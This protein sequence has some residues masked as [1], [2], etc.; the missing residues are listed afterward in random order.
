MISIVMQIT[1]DGNPVEDLS[2][3]WLRKQVGVVS[4]E[5]VLFGVSIAENIRYGRE[6]AT[7]DDIEIAATMAN[8]HGFIDRLPQVKIRISVK[9][10][11]IDITLYISMVK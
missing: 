8:A 4:Q 3:Y 6:D 11:G 1:L 2:L 10:I 5:P 7:Q 9:T